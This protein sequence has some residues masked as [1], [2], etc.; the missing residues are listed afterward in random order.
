[1]MSGLRGAWQRAVRS[2]RPGSSRRCKVPGVLQMEAVECG[3]ASLA[4]V[5]A[6][7]GRWVPLE[8]L[9]AACGVSRDGAKASNLLKAARGFGLTAKGFK[10][11]VEGLADLPL[12]AI[13]HW[14][15]NHFLVLE[16]M[17]GNR[18]FLNDPASGPRTVTLEEFGEGFTGVVLAFEKGE[19]FQ[20]GGARPGLLS[21]L[22]ARLR[23]SRTAVLFIALAA[24]ALVVPGVAI[25]AFSRIFVDGVLVG[26]QEGWL[27]PLL[28]GMVLTAALRAGLTLVQQRLLLRLET[29][30]GVVGAARFVWHVLRLPMGF[31]NQRHAGDV[32][33]RIAANDRVARLL[34]GEMAQSALDLATC[35]CLGL[36]VLSYDPLLGAVTVGMALP[37]MLLLRAIAARQR[38]S[39]QRQASAGA[40]LAAASI[41][42]LQSIETL[43]ASGLENQAFERWAGHQANLLEVRRD[44]GQ[45]EVVLAAAPTLFRTLANVVVLGLGAMRVMDG[46][47]TIGTLVAFQSL[48]ESFSEPIGRF[49]GLSSQAQSAR[50]DLS[51]IDDAFANATDPCLDL[52]EGGQ[53]PARGEVEIEGLSFGYSPLDPPLIQDFSLHLKPGMRVAL[54]GGSGSGKSTVGRLLTGLA[55]PWSGSIRI[56]GRPL[57]G[58]PA[59]ER[60]RLLAAVDQD[61]F[62]F[63]GSVRDNLTLW[64][65]SVPDARLL[66]A[67]EDAALLD[68]VAAR[69]GTLEARVEEGGGNFSGGQRQ[70]LEIARALVSDPSVLV[71][72][73]ATAALDP[74]TEKEI[75]DRLRRRGA[76]CIIIAHRLS[77]VR[78]CDEIVVLQRGRIVERGSHEALLAQGGEYARLI[79]AH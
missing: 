16:G 76:T 32:A 9:R 37:N 77:T 79:S 52:P 57:A 54:V 24:L 56:D 59:A 21:L 75:D 40:K 78:D 58:I 15:F 22:A 66:R 51:R 38:Q 6:H 61:I 53:P 23:S 60:A 62:L 72:D 13:V 42:A 35:L 63:E 47:M 43:K 45:M 68:E 34:S 12:P 69:P 18:V 1:M 25:P 29:R 14:N 50:A 20:P 5:L 64:D 2:G 36:I 33:Q 10:K 71:L 31:F 28:A 70:R 19:G 48:A 39:S 3:A 46:A 7:H 74:T 27:K 4:M 11:E 8:Q 41:G 67:L 26:G 73:E 65:R 55:Q 17:A 49:V 30:L 44:L